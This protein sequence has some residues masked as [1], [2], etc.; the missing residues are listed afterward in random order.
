MSSPDPRQPPIAGLASITLL[1][2]DAGSA[3]ALAALV[4]LFGYRAQSVAAALGRAAAAAGPASRRDSVSATAVP[5]L[6]AAF[7]LSL[8][9]VWKK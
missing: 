6:L 1:S 3:V 8:S 5:G 7:F 2:A 4:A 9:F